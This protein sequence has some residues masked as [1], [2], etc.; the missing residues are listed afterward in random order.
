MKCSKAVVMAACITG[1]FAFSGVGC[2]SGDPPREVVYES[3]Y[4]VPDDPPAPRE[5]VVVVRPGPEY[6][7]YPGYWAWHDHWVWE[8]GRWVLP[9]HPRAIWEPGHWVHQGHGWVW[10][11]GHWR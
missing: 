9:P 2:A 8:P 6:V 5:E 7:W 4:S 11:S 10:H 3:S 1:A